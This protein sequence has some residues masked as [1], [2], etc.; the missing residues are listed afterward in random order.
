[1]G[2]SSVTAQLIGHEYSEYLMP[3]VKI[4]TAIQRK[5]M[6]AFVECNIV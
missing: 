2:N 3:S 6:G 1:V 4:T 5:M